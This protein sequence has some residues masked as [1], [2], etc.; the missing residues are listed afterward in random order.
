MIRAVILASVVLV[1]VAQAQGIAPG[2]YAGPGGLVL[3]VTPGR[4]SVVRQ[5][6]EL[7]GGVLRVSGDSLEMRD[8]A[9]AARC[10]D[11]GR[12]RLST[13][14]DTLRLAAIEDGCVNRRNA[15]TAAGWVRAR[16]AL[17]LSH[18]TVLD[19]TGGPARPGMTLVLRDGRIAALYRD[20]AEPVPED[21]Q[22]RNV[23]GGFVLPG[24][25]DAHVH[26]ATSP[27]GDDRRDRTEARLKGALLGGVVAVRDMG[28]DARLLADLSR[29]VMAGDLAGPEIRYSAIMAGPGFFDDPRVLASSRGVAPGQAPWAR[30]ITD[31]TDLRQVVAEA[32]GAG[33]TAIKIYAD[34]APAL[35]ARVSVEAR[36]QG[37][38]VWA[39]LALAPARPGDV[40]AG[41][42]QVVSHALLV[43]WEVR[44][45]PDWKQ[46]AQVD[47]T[48]SPDHAAI[49]ALFAAMKAKGAIWDPTL[50]V[51]RADSSAADTSISRRRAAR[52]L[53]FVRAAHGAGVRIAAGTDGMGGDRG[54]P[55]IHEELALLVRAGLT[56][57]EA[58][59]AA[60]RTGADALG[61]SASHGT[62]AVGKAADLLVLRA[63]PT[64]DIRNTRQ[65]EF[66]L[67]RGKVV[68]K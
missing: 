10:D 62:I 50:F 54:L 12:F 58:L 56:P 26:I 63:D 48:I 17:V 39:H 18:A 41:G 52:A 46:R 22:E 15:L 11:P 9:G 51:Y 44:Q 16:D 47:L 35:L 20:G 53:D 66:V 37:L 34:V 25:I 32:K 1:Q 8:D 64:A 68:E 65:I 28:G 57:M 40:V 3:T 4:Y 49:R 7:I 29:A 60:T 27:S 45:L 33:A 42:V 13:A 61:L 31:S 14:G 2:R 24:L 59:I 55:N 67:K 43:P 23:N 6:R 21:A 19:M 5:G 30:A 36:R 38:G